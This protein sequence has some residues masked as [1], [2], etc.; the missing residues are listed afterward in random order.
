LPKTRLCFKVC[1]LQ[2]R[3]QVLRLYAEN[4]RLRIREVGDRKRIQHLIAIAGP[5]AA[6]VKAFHKCLIMELYTMRYPY[7]KKFGN[8]F[9][10]G[11]D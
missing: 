8:L 7:V 5:A 4:D 1:I 9:K 6:E 10:L 11:F 3:E 2:E